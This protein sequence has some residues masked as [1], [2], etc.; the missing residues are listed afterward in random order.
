M[1][2][3]QFL[4]LL[5]EI[6]LVGFGLLGLMLFGFFR[7]TRHN[8]YLWAIAVAF[9]AQWFFFSGYPNSLHVFMVLIL[10]YAFSQHSKQKR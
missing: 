8:P 5:L 1:V 6:G 7:K 3:N 4:E 2:Q 9:L 10:V